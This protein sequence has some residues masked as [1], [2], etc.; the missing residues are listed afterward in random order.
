MWISFPRELVDVECRLGNPIGYIQAGK[1]NFDSFHCG[2][3]MQL[4]EFLLRR[5]CLFRQTTIWE[6]I[7]NAT[8]PLVDTLNYSTRSVLFLSQWIILLG[9][10]RR[11]SAEYLQYSQKE[12]W[13][14]NF[15]STQSRSLWAFHL[16]LPIV[17]VYF[18]WIESSD[19]TTIYWV[20]QM[21]SSVK[22]K[23]M[24]WVKKNNAFYSIMSISAK[25]SVCIHG[26]SSRWLK[27]SSVSHGVNWFEQLICIRPLGH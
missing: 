6:S 23:E 1:M 5:N 21:K 10:S 3:Q 7:K 27:Q 15:C 25:P 13:N 17:L 19:N 12:N 24:S 18:G 2:H 8:A 20:E 9:C 22:S 11:H 16:Y 26:T 4:G 14:F